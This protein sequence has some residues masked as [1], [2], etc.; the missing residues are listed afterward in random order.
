MQRAFFTL[1]LG[2]FGLT[3]FQLCLGQ[4]G[5]PLES[6]LNHFRLAEAWAPIIFHDTAAEFS[7]AQ[8]GFNPVDNLLDLFFDG[9]EDVTDNADNLFR[10]SVPLIENLKQRSPLY[11][12]IVETETHYYVG[13]FLYHAIDAGPEGHLHDTENIWTVVEKDGS[14]FGR[15]VMHITNAHGFAMIYGMN[16][17]E[18]ERWRRAL[19][20]ES[21]RTVL[22]YLDRYSELHQNSGAPEFVKRLNS[23]ALKIFV[24]SKSH[25]LYKFSS[26]AWGASERRG[27]IIYIPE[28][29]EECLVDVKAYRDPIRPYKLLDWDLLVHTWLSKVERGEIDMPTFLKV[30]T[31]P[32]VEP[33]PGDR[34]YQPRALPVYLAVGSEEEDPKANLFHESSLH[35]HSSLRTP[36]HVHEFFAQTSSKISKK[37][38]FNT[39]VREK[40]DLRMADGSFPARGLSLFKMLSEVF[41]GKLLTP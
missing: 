17:E 31:A 10:L 9:N 27:G 28:H 24:A 34:E 37:Y 39:Y 3:S 8:T 26:T 29:C 11:F 18:Q 6:H 7:Q 4:V 13:Y 2:F 16:P 5:D 36:V 32:E 23:S 14:P 35:S 12:S 15:L 19:P 21:A 33:L 40:K 22:P 1:A 38:L 20:E 25:A 41:R 30:F